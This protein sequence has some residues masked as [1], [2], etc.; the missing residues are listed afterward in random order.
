MTM[1]CRGVGPGCTAIGADDACGGMWTAWAGAAVTGSPS[2]GVIVAS[3]LTV[4]RRWWR[5]VGSAQVVVGSVIKLR[6]MAWRPGVIS[7]HR[8][9]PLWTAQSRGRSQNPLR[10][11]GGAVLW[12][13]LHCGDGVGEG[14]CV[15]FFLCGWW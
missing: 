13:E 9:V 12:G 11:R 10:V 14:L 15:G 4:R 6:W 8:S 2:V 1:A 7:S 3:P 5:P